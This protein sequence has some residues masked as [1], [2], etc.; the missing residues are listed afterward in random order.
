MIG[1]VSMLSR[2]ICSEASFCEDW[3]TYHCHRL[4]EDM[5]SS[6]HLYPRLVCHGLDSRELLANQLGQKAKQHG[7]MSHFVTM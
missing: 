7:L 2:P 6:S 4:R 3:V 5:S 1:Y